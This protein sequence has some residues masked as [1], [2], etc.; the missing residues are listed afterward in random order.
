MKYEIK[1][2]NEVIA[3]VYAEG[4]VAE[5]I[6]GEQLVDATFSL[7][8]KV[9]FQLWDSI[10][11]DGV[12]YFLHTTPVEEKLSNRNFRYTLQFAGVKYFL[13]N[14]LYFFPDKNNV[15]SVPDFSITGTA[16][17]MLELLVQNANREQSGWSLGTVATDEAK[18]V[19]FSGHTCLSALSKIASEFELEYWVDADKSIHLEERIHLTDYFFG[20][21]EK[22]GLKGVTKMPVEGAN[23]VTRLYAKGGSKNL[24]NGYRNYSKNL[25]M[26]VPFLEKNTNKYGVIETV[27]SFDDIFPHRIG[28]VTAVSEENPLLFFDADMPFDL[29]KRDKKGNT[30]YLIDKVSAKVTFNT[31]QLAGYTFE[32]AEYGYDN[33][34]KRFTLLT[35]KEEEHL[36][37]PSEAMRPAVGDEYVLT[38]IVLPQSYIDEAE[39]KLQEKAQEYLN[40][41]C[42]Q[43]NIYEVIADPI[44]FEEQNVNIQVGHSC[45]FIEHDLQLSQALRV[46]GTVKNLQN[47]KEVQFELG[48]TAA[49]VQIVRDYFK[50]EKKSADLLKFLKYNSKEAK[51]SYLFAREISDNVFDSEGYFNPEKIKPLSID[52]KMLTVGSRLQQ[53]N[54]TDVVLTV[55]ENNA[56]VHNTAGDIIHL[57]IADEPRT[58]RIAENTQRNIADGFHYIYV[59]AQRNGANAN[60]VVTTER[61][62]VE[63]DENYYHFETGYLGSVNDGFRRIKTTYGFTQV[64]PGEITTG[65]IS[66]G[67]GEQYVD[68]LQDKVRFKGDVTFVAGSNAFEQIRGEAKQLDDALEIGGRNLVASGK[69]QYVSEKNTKEFEMSCWATPVLDENTISDILEESKKYTISFTA[70]LIERTNVTALYAHQVGFILYAPNARQFHFFSKNIKNLGDREDVTITFECPPI[71]GYRLL[72][73]TNRYTGNGVGYDRVRITNFQIEKGTKATDYSPAPEDL[74]AEV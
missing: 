28:T 22:K 59:K 36:T 31:G 35:N 58:W 14:S 15:L 40:K 55:E 13:A 34:L 65:R 50:N 42:V 30:L 57:T 60:I 20:Y 39:E 21:G 54:L 27:R 6:M 64:S 61:I 16:A 2:G 10:V 3:E 63:Q 5:R 38:D 47:L 51:R 11:V 8:E 73:Y 45:V 4:Q 69:L 68:F 52:T 56:A 23:I 62:M 72:A 70:E 66:S 46:L 25:Q 24:P 29:N 41:N 67:N 33:N 48:E 71:N 7:P 19:D 74:Q 26:P 18:T 43:R 12:T 1:R 53:F 9:F 49:V 44:Y 37:V 17:Q 32:I